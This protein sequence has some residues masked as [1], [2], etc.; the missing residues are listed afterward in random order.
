[1]TANTNRKQWSRKIEYVLTIL[2]FLMGFG[3]LWR[4]PY[5]CMKNGGG[6][7]LIPYLFVIFIV[8]IPVYFLE[9]SL[10]QFSGKSF[11][12][13]WSYCPLVKGLGLGM[14][15]M[16]VP[17]VCYYVMLMTWAAYY[18]YSAF[19]NPL[20]WSTCANEWNT[21][22]CFNIGNTT[23]NRL[24]NSTNDINDLKLVQDQVTSSTNTSQT[25]VTFPVM[26]IQ[27]AAEEFWQYNVLDI[28]TGIEYFGSLKGHI[29][30]C[31]A[32]I[33]TVV[34]LCVIN[35][36]TSTKKVVYVTATIPY[37]LLTILL[38]HNLTLPGSFDGVV[39]FIKP[40]FKSLLN[41]QVWLEAAIQVF[42]SMS[43]GTGLHITLASYNKFNNDCLRDA[44]VMTLA[45]EALTSLFG[46]FVIFT[47][48]GFMAHQANVSIKEVTNS[49]PGLGFVAYP[50][51]LAQMPLS[52]IWAVLFFFAM[53]IL[54][55]HSQ[56]TST[57]QAYNYFE[58]CYP[59]MAK[60][61]KICRG[62]LSLIGFVLTLP[63]CTQVGVYLF[64]LFD[65]YNAAFAPLFFVLV[66]CIS[67]A[68]LY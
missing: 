16:L 24:M 7:F 61:P 67:V 20:P 18:L 43:I 39:F 5:I 23:N 12:N 64:Q 6:A 8:I 3:N 47:A 63:F 2:G 4:F 62:C 10:G 37:L 28:S 17:S 58:E 48:L 49:G 38:V 11:R 29:V 60:K 1:M 52:N 21:V 36:I 31:L 55:V 32:L 57:E 40:D 9:E 68:W 53:V 46:G 56:F 45:G 59:F 54:G 34:Y 25:S 50:I 22:Y 65:W 26:K 51:A 44:F 42:H 27:N 66:E 41:I 19:H 30:I 15:V 33:W 14:Q 13:V 35:G